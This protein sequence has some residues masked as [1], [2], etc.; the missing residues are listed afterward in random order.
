MRSLIFFRA[1]WRCLASAAVLDSC[2]FENMF[3]FT[4]VVIKIFN[5]FGVK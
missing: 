1:A 4:Y 5:S 2:F 3:I